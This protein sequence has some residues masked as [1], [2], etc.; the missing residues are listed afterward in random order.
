MTKM[1]N[2]QQIMQLHQKYAVSKMAFSQVWTHCQIVLE[3]AEQLMLATKLDVDP[4]LVRAGCLLHDI[5]VYPLIDAEAMVKPGVSYMTHGIVGKA[6][7]RDEG[8]PEALTMIAAHHT[9]VGLSK[10]DVIVQRL[11]LPIADYLAKT[12]EERLIMYCDKFHS[13]T[14]PPTFNSF[15][16]YRAYVSQFGD[17]KALQF[18]ALAKSFGLPRLEG[19]SKKY[20]HQLI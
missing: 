20:G 3:I 1:P 19:L 5:G 10:Q 9:G 16:H 14:L 8:L 17:D 12:E 2:E 7:L 18:D 13:K 11:P 15:K 4:Q 6:I